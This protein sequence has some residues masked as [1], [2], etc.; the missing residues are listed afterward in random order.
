MKSPYLRRA[1]QRIQ[2]WCSGVE[3]AVGI[4]PLAQAKGGVGAGAVR[5]APPP[6]ATLTV[7]GGGGTFAVAID[8]PDNVTGPVI[9]ELKVSA[10]VPFKGSSTVNK[11]PLNPATYLTI[12]IPNTT[13]YF[14]LR[15]RYYTSDFNQPVV[16]GPVSSGA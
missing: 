4:D 9:N 8:L 6:A 12:N 14:Q 16:F 11:Y 5:V 7:V 10:T 13:F 15:S 2:D 1:L 3:R